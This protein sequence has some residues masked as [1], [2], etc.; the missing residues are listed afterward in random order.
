MDKVR[1][2][3]T[4]GSYHG[5]GSKKKWVGR[6][7]LGGLQ[8]PVRQSQKRSPC[9]AQNTGEYMENH[10]LEAIGLVR[11]ENTLRRIGHNNE[12]DPTSKDYASKVLNVEWFSTSNRTKHRI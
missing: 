12:K 7:S 9:V 10:T 3:L 11:E 2:V 4:P 6:R 1:K 5:V 8:G